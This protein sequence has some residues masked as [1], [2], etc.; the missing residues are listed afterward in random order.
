MSVLYYIIIALLG[1]AAGV[2][3]TLLVQQKV[4]KSRARTLMEEAAR[5]ADVLKK[6]KLLEAREQ[7]LK[8]K[9][10]AEKTASQRM[11]KVQ[12]AEARIKQRELQQIGRASCRERV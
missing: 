1:L 4:G 3:I 12:S 11:A 7:E 8:I 5:E 2:G 9:N 6:N 10:E